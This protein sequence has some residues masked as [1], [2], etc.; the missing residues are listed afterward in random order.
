ME[1]SKVSEEVIS[2]DNFSDS[3]FSRIIW[4]TIFDPLK[5]FKSLQNKPRW[6]LPFILSILVVFTSLALTSNIKMEDVKADIRL[7]HNLD[8]SEIDRRIG[9]IDAQGTHGISWSRIW[10]GIVAVTAIQT[11]KLFGIALAFWLAFHLIKSQI[12]YKRILA[13]CS[14][15]FLI[16]IPEA[17]IKIP[18]ILAKGTTYI[19]LGPAVLL[20]VEWKYSPLFK[21]LDKLDIF[22]IWMA[23][24]MV[25]GFSVML[26]ISKRKS[27][28]TVGYLWGIWLLVSMFVGD[29]VQIN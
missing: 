14:F 19:Y 25:I 27:V 4:D 15:A 20:P 16:L 8:Q 7:S 18:L 6:L 17:A 24:L 9:N 23:V 11:I 1:I 21:L 5:A 28:I 13:I 10:L 22:T 12:S 29:L 3:S 26:D 2:E